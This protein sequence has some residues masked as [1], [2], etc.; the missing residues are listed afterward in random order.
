M[1]FN[2]AKYSQMMTQPLSPEP[3]AA[4]PMGEQPQQNVEETGEYTEEQKQERI[5]TGDFETYPFVDEGDLTDYL[6]N[7]GE[8]AAQQQLLN[9]ASGIDNANSLGSFV[10]GFYLEAVEN[11]LR[12][13]ASNIWPMIDEAAKRARPEN[14]VDQY[15]GDQETMETPVTDSEQ[16][17]VVMPTVVESN[18]QIQKLAQQHSKEAKTAKSEGFNL[19]KYAQHKTV[20]ELVLHG[21]NSKRI[22]PFTG[23]L[24]SDWHVI[25]R[26]KGW[27]YRVGD[28]WNL[29]FE[30]F[31]R[32]NIMDK[33]SR[34]YRDSDGNWVGGYIEKR[35]EVDKWVPE[36]NNLQYKPGQHRK[37]Y[38]PEQRSTEA[39]LE[40]MR[41]KKD[42]GYEPESDGDP[43]DWNKKPE[44]AETK[45][46][47]KGFNLKQYKEAQLGGEYGFSEEANPMIHEQEQQIMQSDDMRDAQLVPDGE[48]KW[49]Y[50]EYTITYHPPPIPNRSM[51]YQWCHDSYDGAPDAGDDRCGTAGSL[52]QAMS[53]IDALGGGG[54]VF[55]SSDQKKK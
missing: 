35:F 12:Y 19:S 26:N 6:N 30:Q 22:S 46:A 49:T 18:K 38:I 17:K 1:A 32:Q 2:L 21:P 23:Q 33:Y 14:G 36:E 50:G 8:E 24:E 48:N 20:E 34:P 44:Y 5:A 39:R 27:G 11:R 15:M 31:W 51:D 16:V 54:A 55:A 29:D 10:Q 25:E 41:A 40:A 47:S 7:T 52:E 3:M 45:I 28:L 42:R 37:P 4:D 13:A 53:D 9:F 43:Y